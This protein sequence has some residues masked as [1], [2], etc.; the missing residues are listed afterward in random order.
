MQ[1]VVMPRA[2][3]RWTTSSSVLAAW[4]QNWPEWEWCEKGMFAGGMDGIYKQ[5]SCL[6]WIVICC[7]EKSF[8][9]LISRE[10]TSEFLDVTVTVDGIMVL[11]IIIIG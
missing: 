10:F 2:M 4:P 3:A 1:K 6:D 8:R 5:G 11:P 9:L 7:D